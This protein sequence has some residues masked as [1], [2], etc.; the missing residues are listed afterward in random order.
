MFEDERFPSAVDLCGSDPVRQARVLPPSSCSPPLLW[1]MALSVSVLVSF[2][3]GLALSRQFLGLISADLQDEGRCRFLRLKTDQVQ[4]PRKLYF[5][6]QPRLS[7]VRGFPVR[8]NVGELIDRGGLQDGVL[9]ATLRLLMRSY[10]QFFPSSRASSS[11]SSPSSTLTIDRSFGGGAFPVEAVGRMSSVRSPDEAGPPRRF[12]SLSLF[13]DSC[14]PTPQSAA[15]CFS[16]SF[17]PASS[18][19]F[20]YST[21]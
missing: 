17:R 13:M 19:C 15:L 1:M 7:S 9:P 6:H 4:L 21:K 10:T 3:R 8:R 16:A 20:Q 2:S 11:V 12:L 18:R 14:S 5:P